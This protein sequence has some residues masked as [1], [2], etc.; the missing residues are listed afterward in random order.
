MKHVRSVPASPPL[1]SVDDMMCDRCPPPAAP[2]HD[3]LLAGHVIRHGQPTDLL[4][5]EQTVRTRLYRVSQKFFNTSFSPV[6]PNIA[7]GHSGMNLVFCKYVTKYVL[8]LM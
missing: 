8:E 6:F 4:L 3:V 1:L 5:D 7:F 2:V